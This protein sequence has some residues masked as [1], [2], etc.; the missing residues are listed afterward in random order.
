MRKSPFTVYYISN[1]LFH[2][3]GVLLHR[4]QQGGPPPQQFTVKFTKHRIIQ[5]F[6]V[7]FV[8]KSVA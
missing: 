7:V 2:C 4:A 6:F 5:N 8:I 3:A 1:L